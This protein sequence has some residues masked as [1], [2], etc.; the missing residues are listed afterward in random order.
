METVP[1]HGRETAYEVIDCGG[2]GL[3]VCWIH[4]S[5]GTADIWRAQEQLADRY[6]LVMLDLSGHGD[7]SDIDANTGYATLSAYADDVLAVVEE[8]DARVLVGSSLGGAV[9]L[10]ILLERDFDPE[11]VVLTGT[12][13]RLGVLDDLLVWL[14]QDFERALAFL[15][16]PG[17]LF[18]D[19]DPSLRERSMAMMETTGQAVMRRD[20]RTCH[21]FDVRD[22]LEDIDIPTLAICGENDQLTPP[23]YHE[24]LADEIDGASWVALEDS[25]HLVMLEQP[26]TFNELV[27]DFLA[28]T[29]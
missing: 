3:P 11:A 21:R 2:N 20:F 4:G 18:A 25:A 23:W 12:G 15:H 14:E 9:V 27:D 5:G 17:R 1:H 29:I 8:T 16:A 19:P 26:D 10:H 22:R 13:A 28:E 24:F 6:P 7:S